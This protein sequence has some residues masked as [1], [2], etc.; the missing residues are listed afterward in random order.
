MDR[1]NAARMTVADAYRNGRIGFMGVELYVAPGALVPREETELLGRTAL[2]LLHDAAIPAPRVVDMCC[3]AGN[4]ACAIAC[5]L[6]GAHVWAA[7]L[8][9]A[10]VEIARRNVASLGLENRVRVC[11]GDLFGGLAGLGLEGSLDAI[12]CNPPYI[13][14]QR[15]AGDRAHL[16]EHE[17]RAAFDGGPYGIDIHRRVLRDAPAFLRAGGTLLFEVGLGQGRQVKTLFERAG[18]YEEVRLVP[19][20][21]GEA[22]VALGRRK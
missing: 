15:L 1:E 4:L 18:S 20:G 9:D 11:Q 16:L 6:P 5:N 17:P 3:G 8:T 21:T 7:D 12:V 14:A 22:R 10:C 13:S 2:A 19:D